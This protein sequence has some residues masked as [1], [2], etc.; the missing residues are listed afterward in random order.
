M[1]C[2]FSQ[3]DDDDDDDDDED[4]DEEE[5]DDEDSEKIPDLSPTSKNAKEPEPKEASGK[6]TKGL[7]VKGIVRNRLLNSDPINKILILVHNLKI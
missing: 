7:P 2:L 6:R 3:D 4:D 1:F 5:E